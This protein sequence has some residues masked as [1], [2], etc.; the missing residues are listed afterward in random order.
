[1]KAR[2]IAL[3][4]AAGAML[5][6]SALGGLNGIDGLDDDGTLLQRSV[7]IA[8]VLYAA[9]G[10]AAGAGVLFRRR[11][12][13]PLAIVWAI[14][15][16]YTGSVASVA[17]AEKGQPIFAPVVGAFLLCFVI[18]GFVVWCVHIATRPTVT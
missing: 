12:S 2:Y 9:F 14:L 18:C 7:S 17:W 10:L 16:T 8:S 5:I 1:M 4:V 11:W 6:L 13:Y 15:V 3:I